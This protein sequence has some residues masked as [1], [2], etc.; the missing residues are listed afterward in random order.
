VHRLELS[1]F[2]AMSALRFSPAAAGLFASLF[3]L[4]LP[5]QA[6]RGFIFQSGAYRRTAVVHPVPTVVVKQAPTPA[7]VVVKVDPVAAAKVQKERDEKLSAIDLAEKQ[8]NAKALVGVDE[9]VAAFLKKRTEDGSADAPYDLAQRH[10][11]GKGVPLDPAEARRLYGLA[12]ERGNHDA[13]RWL[14]EHPSAK[15][16]SAQQ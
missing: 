3:V 8:R 14:K 15:P 9:R 16:A 10:E 1:S 7:P 2:V 4:Q 12:A 5:A 11:T 6:A 13:E